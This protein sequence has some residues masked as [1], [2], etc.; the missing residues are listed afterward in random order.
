MTGVMI[1]GGVAGLGVLVLAFVIAPPRALASSS[2][3]RLD[4]SRSERR[5]EVAAVRLDPR[6]AGGP[7]WIRGFGRQ[8]VGLLGSWGLEL[9]QLRSDISLL[10]RGLD[11]FMATTV[12]AALSGLLVPFAVSAGLAAAGVKVVLGVPL[13]VGVVAAVLGGVLP[14]ASVRSQ[15][16]ARR[17]DFRHAV[18]SFLD[19]VSMSL[20][21]GRGVPEAL[22]GASEL[23]DGWGVVRIRNTL[24][25]AR[26]RGETPWAALGMLGEELRIDELRDLGAAL[27]L[28]AED[29]AKVRDSLAA[30]ADSM[31]RRELAESEGR[32]GEASQSMLV[33]Q[34]LLALGFL[35][36]LIY[37]A[38]LSVMG[39]M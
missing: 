36:F 1:A 9:G 35:V 25:A 12:L 21:G 37:P 15:A 30:R 22:Q 6:N 18:G 16:A 20:A 27:A 31:R 7:T 8:A 24:I 11:R 26:L 33:A 39:G 19:L 32:A 29:G 34:L 10:G 4:L 23:S 2:L 5:A 3:A 17:R 28:V 14:L 13:L 38:I